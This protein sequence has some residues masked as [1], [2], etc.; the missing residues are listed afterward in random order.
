MTS[1]LTTI[2]VSLRFVIGAVAAVPATLAMDRMMARLPEGETPPF[3]AAGVLTECPPNDAS[4]RLAAVVHYVA[5][6]LTGPLFVWISLSAEAIAGDP[7]PATTLLAAA[8]LYALMI[9]FFAG[10]VLPRSRV[11]ADRVAAIRRDW[12]VAAA[13]YLLALVLVASAA[14]RLV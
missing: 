5:G 3:V 8:V 9:G 13:T 7:S 12:V 11:A 4:P 10:V 2:D 1:L 6:G 14:T